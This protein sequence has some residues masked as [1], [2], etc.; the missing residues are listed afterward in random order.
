M[1]GVYQIANNQKL[2]A[3][4]AEVNGGINLNNFWVDNC[5]K[6]HFYIHLIFFI[7]SMLRAFI[8]LLLRRAL[9]C[10]AIAVGYQRALRV[11]P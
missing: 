1:P 4:T 8:A 6:I 7:N 2:Q 10:D 3:M 9:Y 5:S 11:V